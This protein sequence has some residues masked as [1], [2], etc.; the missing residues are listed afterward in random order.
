M[1]IGSSEFAVVHSLACAMQVRSGSLRVPIRT[2][3]RQGRK[4]WREYAGASESRPLPGHLNRNDGHSHCPDKRTGCPKATCRTCRRADGVAQKDAP[5][6][7]CLPL[8][9]HSIRT[10]PCAISASDLVGV[11]RL[12]QICTFVWAPEAARGAEANNEMRI[13]GALCTMATTNNPQNEA[14]G[15]CA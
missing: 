8:S 10:M 15:F 4:S 2:C 1:R 5:A 3:P 7:Q 12:H 14:A 13:G 9:Q 11:I 6:W